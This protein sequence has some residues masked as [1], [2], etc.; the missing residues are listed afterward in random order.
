M[1]PTD[2][3][4]IEV[5]VD[6]HQL[7]LDRQEKLQALGSALAKQRDEWIAARRTAGI[8]KRM[9]DD[10]DQYHNLD[11]TNKSSSSMMQNV[12]Q[13]YAQ[14]PNTTRA[15]RST[16][17]VGVTRQ[18]TNAA[19]ARLCDIVLPS[20][21]SNF[22][23]DPTP[24]PRLAK[25]L[26][27][28]AP[29][30]DPTTGQTPQGPNGQPL[31]MSDMAQAVQAAAAASAKAMQAEIETQFEACD[32]YA[33]CRKMIHNAALFGTGVLKGPVVVSRRKKSWKKSGLPGGPQ[34][35]QMTFTESKDPASYSVDPR[36]VWPDPSCG[37]DVQ[38]GRGIYEFDEATTK[39][40]RDLA[41]QPLYIREQLLKVLEAGPGKG[42]SARPSD[43]RVNDER[44]IG[45][46][47]TFAWWTYTGEIDRKALEEAGLPTPKDDLEVASMVIEM[48]DDTVVRA[49]VN[50]LEDG[51]LPYDFFPWEKVSDSVWG[52]GIPYLMRA[53]QQVTNAAWRQIMD[54]AGITSGPQI[55]V[56]PGLVQ[57]ADKKWEITARKIWFATDDTQDVRTAFTTV[58]FDSRQ[59]E[60]SNILTMSEKLS[61]QETATPMMMQGEKG[62]APETV[63]GMTML[64]NN[65]NTVLRR[66]VKQYDDYVTRLHVHRYYDFNMLYSDKE[67]IKGDFQVLARGSSALLIRDIQHQALNGLM[68]VATNP[69]FAPMINPKK[70]FEKALRAQHLD[71]NDIMR[72][73]QEI[74]QMEQ[75]A[76]QNQKPD[77]RVQAAQIRAQADVQRAQAQSAADTAEIQTRQQMS[78][79]DHQ[80]RL[81]ELQVMK[82]IEMLK[83]STT[84]NIS[85][86]KIK[87]MLADTALRERTKA[88]MFAA[89]AQINERTGHGI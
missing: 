12:A 37:D 62:S 81:A 87:A 79:R 66:L 82:E 40:V 77:P 41:K 28:H 83:L 76:Q 20:D 84:Q 7:A 86:E 15:T 55:I 85:L 59:Q 17:F 71:P 54:N 64:M 34:V 56:K 6:E 48:I 60:L 1:N 14:A 4:D 23:V 47:D 75:Q 24:D 61:D 11:A 73:D 45:K 67:D 32:F 51:S 35:Y 18:K 49:Y 2:F 29:A 39:R 68:Q 89:E 42:Q 3:P 30:T 19:E 44:N 22:G 74:Q 9:A 10:N 88:Q 8:D 57:P 80:F 36:K 58:Q 13:G 27:N 52:Y 46:D 70:L 63:G 50:P 31:K 38:S 33:E 25:Q 53:Q 16:L 72:T 21:D 69:V 78:D 5:E 65:T 26:E 43:F